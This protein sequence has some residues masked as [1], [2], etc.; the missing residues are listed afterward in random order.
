MMF[1]ATLKTKLIAILGGVVAI[2]GILFAVRQSGKRAA[3]EEIKA[4]TVDKII[5]I[6]KKE[7]EID[8]DIRDKPISDIRDK[9][10]KNASDAK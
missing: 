6:D 10:R 9:L 8:Q 7:R 5:E 1:L 2:L 4:D 3:R